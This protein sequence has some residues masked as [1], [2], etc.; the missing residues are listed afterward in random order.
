[1]G[2]SGFNKSKEDMLVRLAAKA[3]NCSVISPDLFNK[4]IVKRGLRDIGGIGV[5]VGLTEIGDVH[6]YIIDE[7]EMIPV[8][9]RLMYRGIDINEI[10]NGFWTEGRFGFEETCYLL[11]FGDLPTREQLESLKQLLVDDQ[12]LP[13]DF[14]RDTIFKSPSRDMMNVISRSVLALYSY[15]DN[16]DDTSIQNVL[17]QCLGLIACFPSLAVYG[18]QAFSHFQSKNSLFIHSP[19]PDLGVAEN[20][21]HMLRSDSS[22]TDLEA[23]LLDLALVLHAEHGGGNNS[24]FVTHVV[25][26]SGTD[27]YSVMAAAL[28]SLK[29]PRHGGA[30][31]KVVQMFE[32]MQLNIKKWDDEEEIEDYLIKLLNGEAFDKQGLI[33]GVGH[34]VYSISDPRAIILK[35]AAALLAREKGLE[36]EFELY[37]RV[38]KLAPH[39]IAKVRKI[40]KGVSVNVDFYSGFVYRMLD[41]PPELFTPLFAIARILGW[42]AHRIE[43]LVNAG[44]IIRPAYKSVT[45]RRAY[46]PFE[47]RG[48]DQL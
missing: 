11:L 25:T 37:A 21:L 19:S 46:I 9:G 6:S 23:R 48:E 2:N 18:Y 10:V 31:A 28:G 39:A 22:Y 13:P 15:D 17:R 14:V 32:D 24:S 1:M 45:P 43:E 33:Y 8:P 34:A 38:E 42:S 7:N 36:G 4:Y 47:N 29:G 44:K 3:E 20:I 41:I 12:N 26:S 5:L 35:K 16:A 40:Y 30:N 27:T